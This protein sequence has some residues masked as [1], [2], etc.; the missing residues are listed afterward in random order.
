MHTIVQARLTAS[1]VHIVGSNEETRFEQKMEIRE[2]TKQ[3]FIL[4]MTTMVTYLHGTEA[5]E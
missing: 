5:R 4:L 3:I 1:C 2:V